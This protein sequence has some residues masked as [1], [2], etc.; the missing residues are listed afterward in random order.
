[1]PLIFGFRRDPAHVCAGPQARVS[2][3]TGGKVDK[4]GAGLDP[5]ESSSVHALI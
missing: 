5:I 1:M 2:G 3:T 4:D